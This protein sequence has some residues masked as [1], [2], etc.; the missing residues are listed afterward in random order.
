MSAP[1]LVVGFGLH[2]RGVAAALLQR[3]EPLRVVDDRDTDELRRAAESLGVE[4]VAAPDAADWEDLVS[5]AAALVPTPGLPFSHPAL[6]AAAAANVDVVAEFD[7]AQ[8]WDDRPVAA[9][10]GTDGKTTVT[11]LVR[12]ML[13]ASGCSAVE[14]GNVET[15]LVNAI[16]DPTVDV[17]V[18]EASSFR[19]GYC[20]RFRPRVGTWLNFG[21]DHLDVHADLAAYEAAKANIWHRQ[22]SDDVAIGGYDDPVVMRNLTGPA[23]CETFGLAGG[24]HHVRDGALVVGGEPLMEV[25]QMWRALPHDQLNALA[26]AATAMAAGATRDGIVAGL[27]AFRGLP[28]RVQ[29]VGEAHGV[30]WY[31]DS[32]ATTP[33]AVTAGVGGFDSVVLLVG[34]RNKGLD[35]SPL[36]SLAPRLRGVVVMGDAAAEL[37]DVFGSVTPTHQAT[38]MTNAVEIAGTLA[39]PGDVVVLSPGCTS[40]DWYANYAARGDDFAAAV[41]AALGQVA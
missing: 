6:A 9:I 11:T 4:L 36:R 14:A 7:L 31:N 27:R 28:H 20:R 40:Y 8:V 35:L 19:L 17:F 41:R 12:D 26:A 32:K 38:S 30:R 5:T 2:G 34:G 24:T 15:P 18:V 21:P 10:T 33:H 37:L 22:T 16:D 1:Y 23:R 29:L 25:G 39:Q 3:S 13:V